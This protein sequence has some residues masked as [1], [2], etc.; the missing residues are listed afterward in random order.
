MTMGHWGKAVHE[1]AQSH[2]KVFEFYPELESAADD[3]DALIEGASPQAGHTGGQADHPVADTEHHKNPHAEDGSP[4][5][6]QGPPA[7]SPGPLAGSLAP[8]DV[9]MEGNDAVRAG[10]NELAS[11]IPFHAVNLVISIAEAAWPSIG[12]DRRKEYCGL[13]KQLYE[14]ATECEQL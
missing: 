7:P 13:M 1:F 11:W 8:E 5:A 4:S 6:Q 12:A 9:N 3:T 2:P 10:S 14:S